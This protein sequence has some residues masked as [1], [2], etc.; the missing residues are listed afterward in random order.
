LEDKS[1]GIYDVEYCII[2]PLTKQERIVKAKGKAWFEDDKKGYRLNGILQDITQQINARIEIEKTASHLKLAT[3]SANAGTWS[4]D[5][6]TQKLEWSD[7]HKRMWGYDEHRTDLSY[8]DWHELLL[9]GDKEKA[10]EKVEEARVSHTPYQADYCIKRADDGA[11]RHVRSYGKY[12]YDHN[13]EAEILTGISVDIT[14]QKVDELKLKASEEKYRGLFKTM[15][16]GFCIIEMI[17]DKDNKPVDYLFIEANGMFEKHSGTSN[18]VGKTIKQLVPNMEERWF[19]IY[20][21]VALTGEANHF[22]EHSEGLNRWFEVHTFRLEDQMGKNIAVLFTDITERKLAEEKMQENETQFRVFANSIQNLAWIAG[23]DGWIHWYNDRWYD[24]TGTTLEEMQGWGWQKVHHPDHIEKVTEASIELW[25]KPEPFEL[26]FP[27]RRHDGKYRWFLTRAHPVIDANGKIERW[28]GT[29]TDIT[30]QKSFTEELEKRVQERTAE[31]VVRNTFIQTLIDSSLDLIIAIDKDL[32]YLSVN[33]AANKSFAAHFPDGVIGKKIED[34]IPSVHETGVYDK[35]RE[36]LRG[37]TIS[38]KEYLSFYEKKYYDVD[39]IPLRN[40]KEIYGVMSISRD[41]TE[42]VL[43]TLALKKANVELEERKNLVETILESSKEYIAVYA[44]DFSL[45]T[46][47]KATEILMGKKRKDVIGK[48]LLELIPQSKGSKE[49]LDLT[50]ALEGNTIYNE[51]YHSPLTGRYIENYINPL[52]DSEGNVYAAV[53]LGND[54]SNIISRQ[55]EIENARKQLQ[56]QNDI[57]EAAEEIAKFGSYTWNIT[58][59]TLVYSDNLFRLLDCEPQEFLPSNEK[60][61]SFI[62]PEDLQEVIDNSKQTIQTDILREISYRIVS[63]LGRK[64]HFRSSGKYTREGDHIMFIGTVQ[65]TSNDIEA[66]EELQEKNQKLLLTN[67]QLASFTY[68]ASHDLQ[69]PLRKIQTF[70]K[71]I[72]ETEKF[73]NITLDY[74]NRIIT[75]VERMRNLI[76]SLL[77]YSRTDMAELNFVSCDLNLIVEESK[78]DLN[79]SI[80]EKHAIIEYKNLSTI[81]GL[82]IQLSQLFTNIIENA[83]KYSRPEIKPVVKI[84]SSII[85]GKKIDHSSASNQKEYH[86]IKIADNG[87]GFE[88]EYATKIF[89]LFQRLHANNAYSGTGVGLAIVKKIVT[90]HNGFIVAEGTPN[91]GSTFTIYIPTL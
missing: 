72:L 55:I 19:Q 50:S 80:L 88:K 45:I 18:P 84:T 53:V 68:A 32:H 78:S 89:E 87:I 56:I 86:V 66:A 60:F 43:A 39:F 37:N 65:D 47:N 40:E 44:K 62:H 28:I 76:V 90:N 23:G 24:F 6:K 58:T 59:G 13:G 27:L 29:N 10:F 41:V 8:K 11:L 26:T 22:V 21:K 36:A 14:N 54:V 15:D 20:G 3:D 67:S 38:Q 51:A 7:L 81:N 34:V 9:P 64:K 17:F 33:K 91:I 71:Y 75:S 25:K 77:D 63:K 46:I 74:F 35:V 30:E 42:K 82:Y 31:L 2:N 52:K 1:F 49:E 16:Q 70:S 48:T 57:F 4:L 85:E 5:I 83:I 69:E 73:S 61:L 79:L 12:H